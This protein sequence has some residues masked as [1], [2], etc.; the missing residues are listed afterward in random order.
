MDQIFEIEY[1]GYHFSFTHSGHF[2][3]IDIKK[4][5][6]DFHSGK[7]P[8]VTLF[9]KIENDLL[10]TK[11]EIRN[12]RTKQYENAPAHLFDADGS[13][14]G[15]SIPA[16]TIRQVNEHKREIDIVFDTILEIHVNAHGEI[17]NPDQNL[18]AI[19]IYNPL[20]YE[21]TTLHGTILPKEG[22]TLDKT[23]TDTIQVTEKAIAEHVVQNMDLKAYYAFLGHTNDEIR[24]TTKDKDPGHKFR[25]LTTH[26]IYPGKPDTWPNP[27]IIFSIYDADTKFAIEEKTIRVNN[28]GVR[29]EE[30][31]LYDQGIHYATERRLWI[32]EQDGEEEKEFPLHDFEPGV[33]AIEYFN[34]KHEMIAAQSYNNGVLQP[35]IDPDNGCKFFQRYDHKKETLT[36][37]YVDDQMRPHTPENQTG[38]KRIYAERGVYLDTKEKDQTARETDYHHG[39]LV[40]SSSYDQNGKLWREITVDGNDTTDLTYNYE[41]DLIRRETQIGQPYLKPELE[42]KTLNPNYTCVTEYIDPET[43]RTIERKVNY[44]NAEGELVSIDESFDNSEKG[45]KIGQSDGSKNMSFNDGTISIRNRFAQ[46]S[47]SVAEQTPAPDTTVSPEG[48]DQKPTTLEP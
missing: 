6:L 31:N 16:V 20:T 37:T 18:P 28:Q 12:T 44:V 19:T 5:L 33:P 45:Q 47:G 23:I 34:Q 3:D 8:F 39:E 4:K 48:G 26:I 25:E 38:A 40:S 46:A 35:Q 10:Y 30:T 2:L 7:I 15:S 43:S 42:D 13:E 29:F 36:T 21:R 27:A 17:Q 11:L 1:Q 22:Q 24:V 14:E 32:L 9:E 41:G